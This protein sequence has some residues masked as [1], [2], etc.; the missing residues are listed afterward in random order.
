MNFPLGILVP[1]QEEVELLVSMVEQP[2]MM[3]WSSRSFYK[4]FLN[5][6]RVV[7]AQS[8]IGKVASSFTASLLIQ[9]FRVG[10]ILVTGVAGG[11]S[12]HIHVG[13]LAIATQ[14]V[15]HDMNCFPLFPKYMIP[16]SGITFYEPDTKLTETLNKAASSF[17]QYEFQQVVKEEIL[18]A[19]G[20]HKPTIHSGLL[21]SGD[22]FIGTENQL[23]EIQKGLP[24][25]L[26]VEMEGAAVAQVCH[27]AGV[28]WCSIRTISDKANAKAHLDFN[29]FLN[30][31]GKIYTSAVARKF[32]EML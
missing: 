20:I 32:V 13:D 1:M 27:D 18:S 16:H 30:Q 31:A 26:F 7:V 25:S 19:L 3:Q 4:G 12:D 14:A 9:H 28:P 5:G 24:D 23:N 17:L 22:Q 21:V 2:E 15:Q 6:K 8:G 29:L 10:A 11:I